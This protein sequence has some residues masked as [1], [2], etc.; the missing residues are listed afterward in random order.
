[1]S[2]SFP[3]RI[4]Q[5]TTRSPRI[6]RP[7]PPE[8]SD[9]SP[10]RICRMIFDELCV[11]A[12]GDIVCS[13]GDPAGLRVYGNV[14]TDRI[15]DVYDGPMY[16]EMRRW[17][18][19]SKPD[20]WCPVTGND[21]GGRISHATTEDG[22]A[23]R[24]VRMLQLEPVG[25]CNLECP[26]CPVTDFET[27]RKVP[28]SR[29]SFLPFEVMLDVVDQL[30]DLEKL[31][32]YNFGEPF[33]HKQAIPFLREVRRRRPDV[34]IHT[35]TNGLAFTPAKIRALADEA[36]LDRVVFSI[37]GAYPESYARYR[38]G[39][40]LE[41]ALGNLAALAGAVEEAGTRDRVE[42]LW[43]Y[44]LFQWN[45]T[46]EEIAEARRRARGL[47]VPIKWVLT[48]TAGA[49][50]RFAQGSEELARLTGV[51]DVYDSM[52]CDLRV[53]DLWQHGGAARG[54]YRAEL[55]A[56]ATCWSG[57]AGS[58]GVVPIRVTHRGTRPWRKESPDA[59]RLGARL[60][61]GTGRF[62]RELPLTPLPPE[63]V[64]PD[65]TGLALLELHL[66]EEPGTYQVLVDVVEEGVC[67]FSER[68]S[69]ELLLRL[70][71]TAGEPTTWDAERI[72][73]AALG[74]LLDQSPGE[75][76]LEY[77]SRELERSPLEPWLHYLTE[78]AG[79]RA[80][81]ERRRQFWQIVAAELE[82]HPLRTK[83]G[84]PRGSPEGALR[85]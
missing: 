6:P 46:D 58:R 41:R 43:Q 79:T 64:E 70:E 63:S 14:E 8:A 3:F 83:K 15:A 84:A 69:A 68:G 56:E 40:D 53:A 60:R 21:C 27:N 45:D 7:V 31:L 16:Q 17:Q 42:L 13:C 30:P 10:P 20:S 23:G 35:S 38:V 61:T 77:W 44:I 54:I 81:E 24:T 28:K 26:E 36:L 22:E 85:D 74:V 25:V 76:A 1:M 39:G 62:L 67:W 66:P 37:D 47:G 72:T 33:L 71:V 19:A 50:E 18:L 11:L 9:A 78:A 34:V 12:N 57:S 55:D 75:G 29:M 59:F 65:G 32:F 5:R 49:S 4:F 80:S 2:R 82:L 73:E 51:Q 52:T 48:H